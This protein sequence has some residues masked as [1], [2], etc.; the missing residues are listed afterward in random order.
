MNEW[1]RS[2]GGCHYLVI[3]RTEASEADVLP[4]RTCEEMGVLQHDSHRTA[5]AV[6]LDPVDRVIVDGDLSRLN[7]E[8]A[9]KQ[10]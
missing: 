5:K 10:V 2:G 7:I 8:K 4:Y 9:G 3:R 1:Q 6:A